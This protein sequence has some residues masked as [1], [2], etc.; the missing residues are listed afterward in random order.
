MMS[1]GL[2]GRKAVVTGA[3]QG[4]GR[5]IASR[6]S[7]DGADVAVLD[8]DLAAAE[9]TVEK[10]AGSGRMIVP[11]ELNVT[12]SA[13]V[14]EVFGRI[15]ETLG[16][17]DIL[18]NNAG[19][20]RD[21]LIIRMTGED[22][23]AVLDVNLTGAFNCSKAVL[24]PM[25]SQRSGKIV[26]IS[27]VIGLMGNAGQTNYAASKAGL[28]GFTK[29]LAK[30]VASRGITVN[31]VAPGFIETRMTENLP[32]RAREALGEKIPLRRTGQPEDV[33]MAVAFLVSS[34]ADYITG[35]VLNVD[36]GMVM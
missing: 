2:D 10:L 14:E 25:M 29:A 6:L 15:S 20:A 35:Q 36:G 30:E 18:V 28:I 21:N 22:W 27:S 26:N 4:I 16:R 32:D 33:A 24:R 31:A 8:I 1:M 3:G 17:I 12:D 9:S 11:F 34:Q 5:A 7:L 13:S 23:Q 19:I